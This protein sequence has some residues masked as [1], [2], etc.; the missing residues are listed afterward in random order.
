LQDSK[1]VK[2]TFDTGTI[3]NLSSR[4]LSYH[5]LPYFQMQRPRQAQC[6]RT[7]IT[8][9]DGGYFTCPHHCGSPPPLQATNQQISPRGRSRSGEE[10]CRSSLGWLTPVGRPTRSL[11]CRTTGNQA[12]VESKNLWREP[13]LG[14]SVK[15]SLSRVK[16]NS[17]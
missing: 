17:R 8:A 6:P 2:P 3:A 15:S 12:F 7:A 1:V 14:L 4:L 9:T 13:P 16:K 11:D 5:H 10:G